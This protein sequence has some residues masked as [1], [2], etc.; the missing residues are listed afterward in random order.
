MNG[1]TVTKGC[2]VGANA[3]LVPASG[4]EQ[5]VLYRQAWSDAGPEQFQIF[6]YTCS[7]QTVTELATADVWCV[8]SSI[9]V[10]ASGVIFISDTAAGRIQTLDSAGNLVG[11][12]GF[13][14]SAYYTHL[15]VD[16]QGF[17]YATD[18][19]SAPAVK[20]FDSSGDLV[21]SF[22]GRFDRIAHLQVYPSGRFDLQDYLADGGESWRVTHFEAD[23]RVSG[24]EVASESD[25]YLFN[26]EDHSG[27]LFKVARVGGRQ[28]QVQSLSSSGP[29]PLLDYVEC[30]NDLANYIIGFDEVGRVY[31]LLD[32]QDP[33][34]PATRHLYVQVIEL[35]S[36]RTYVI[37]LGTDTDLVGFLTRVTIDSHGSIYHLRTDLHGMEVLRYS[38]TTPR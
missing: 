21:Q 31:R 15:G 7:G 11:S 19:G 4:W 34:S 3:S 14:R 5:T 29:H 10:N 37:N 32:I 8:P 28:V 38:E 22:E 13:D 23:G 2:Q 16:G 20:K 33:A 25:Q 1:N 17:L 9:A 6:G 30:E 24:T 12:F 27:T 18:E 36:P 35:N 26:Y